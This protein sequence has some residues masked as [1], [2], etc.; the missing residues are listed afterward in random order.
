MIPDIT[1]I[2]SMT[3]C[4][5]AAN[6]FVVG[7]LAYTPL[8]QCLVS[9]AIKTHWQD[10]AALI[11]RRFRISKI[12]F[13]Q[14]ADVQQGCRV[15]CVRVKWRLFPSCSCRGVSPSNARE[16]DNRSVTGFATTIRRQSACV[17]LHETRSEMMV[18]VTGGL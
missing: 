1:K 4:V 8:Q 18:T 15:D 5:L 10:L 3:D 2:N 9:V 7:G 14:K 16:V 11:V 6:V 12:P 13:G 17:L